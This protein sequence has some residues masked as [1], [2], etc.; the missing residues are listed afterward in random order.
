VTENA[1]APPAETDS[2][3]RAWMKDHAWPVTWAKYDFTHEVYG[4]RSE[5]PGGSHTLRV[6]QAVLEDR[7]GA[8]LTAHLD[9]L[10]VADRIRQEPKRYH[11]VKRQ[12]AE[13]V[14][15]SLDGPPR[16]EGN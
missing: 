13:V 8:E 9:R 10:R 2:A 12:G 1:C 3:V 14:V 11:L 5:A 16:P 4:W 15:E 6:S 7:P